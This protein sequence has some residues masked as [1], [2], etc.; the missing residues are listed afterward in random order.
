MHIALPEVDGRIVTR[1]VSFKGLA[2]RCPHT[3]VD[4]VRYQPD[5]ER[6]AFVAARLR[7]AGAGCARSI[8]PTS[9]SRWIL[10]N[11]PQSEGRIGNGVEARH[12]G[13]R[14]ARARALRDAG[15]AVAD[16]PPDGDALIARL[17]EGVTNDAAVHALRP[18]F[19]S[20]RWPTTSRVS[21]G[22][23]RPCAMR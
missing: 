16:L 21:R 14:A 18:A 3:E 2:Y 6:I 4:V 13:V 9:A 20:F 11:Y 22:C 17:T 19:Q 10:A 12:A 1:A 5:A 7:A 23:R 15:Y 8:T